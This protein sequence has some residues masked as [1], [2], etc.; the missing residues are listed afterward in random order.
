MI[1]EVAASLGNRTDITNDRYIQWLNWSLFDVCG[2]HRRRAANSRSFKCLERVITFP[3][4]VTEGTV[5][6]ATTSSLTSA[7]FT[8]V[9]YSFYDNYVIEITEFDESGSGIT[10]P[11][12]LIGQKRTIVYY[13]PSTATV[14]VYPAWDTTPTATYTTF[15]LYSRIYALS[16]ATIPNFPTTGVWGI[17]RIE[18]VESGTVLTMKPWGE[19]VSDDFSTTGTPTAFSHRGDYIIFDTTPDEAVWYRMW[20]YTYPTALSASNLSAVSNLPTYWHELI[21]LGAIYRGFQKLMEPDRAS[22]AL[23][24]YTNAL[25]NRIDDDEIENSNIAH[26]FKLRV[27]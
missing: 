16:N 15:N 18:D 14:T 1:D 5:T 22:Q 10:T 4:A 20:F 21:V 8:D 25:T 7:T 26:S 3:T 11:D 6:S 13:V 19:L 17:Q 23:I 9:N 2:Q 27:E 24:D 12:G